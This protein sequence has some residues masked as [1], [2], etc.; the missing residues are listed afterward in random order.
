MA[1]LSTD[2]DGRA[3][4]CPLETELRAKQGCRGYRTMEHAIDSEVRDA[5]DNSILA[6]VPGIARDL[7]I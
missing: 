3:L 7:Y 2:F 5:V 6:T 4:A 1:T